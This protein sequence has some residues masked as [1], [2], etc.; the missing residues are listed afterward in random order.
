MS[1]PSDSQA[2]FRWQ[3]LF[4][5]A[6]EAVFV[7]NRRRR[8]L[9]VNQA[10]ES[11]TGLSAVE[12]R[13]LICLRR[14]PATSDPPDVIIRALCCPPPEVLKGQMGKARRLF[15]GAGGRW[16][17]EF[18]P[19]HDS[20]QL[21]CVLGKIKPLPRQESVLPSALP[22]KLLALREARCL[23]YTFAQLASDVPSFRRVIEQVR[24]ACATNVPVLIGG[25]PGTGK[26]WIARTIHHQGMREGPFTALDAAHLPL[27]SV[28]DLLSRR[29]TCYLR[30]PFR[31]PRDQQARLVAFLAEM[32]ED[33]GASII[34]GT[35]VDAVEEIRNGRVLEELHGALSTLII[36]LPALRDRLADLGVLVERLLNRANAA[37]DTRVAGITPSAWDVLRAYSWP[38]NLRELYAVLRSACLHAKGER[39][40]AGD[41]PAP[42]RL[43]VR[44]EQ[45]P[46]A[47]SGKLL[48]LDQLLEQAER[49]LIQVALRKAHG[50]RSRAAQL[51]AVWRPRLLR[52]ME[53]LGITEESREETKKNGSRVN[54]EEKEDN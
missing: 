5:R 26:C 38:G 45:N 11:L 22:D 12:A 19:L 31:L 1:A 53:A 27:G 15:P 2:E 32:E 6:R 30:E 40:D 54:R 39:I 46:P 47:A 51:L 8:I 25:E 10:W 16:E 20:Q 52:R 14:Q 42:V 49:R 28:V 41:L 9:F 48:P 7:L 23:E 21:L 50:N 3:A 34:A 13:G 36:S 4:Q 43:A 33:T 18:F 44:L 24:L 35:S 17:I 29:A 37:C